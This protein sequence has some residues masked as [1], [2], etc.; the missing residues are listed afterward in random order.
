M[1][2]VVRNSWMA[3]EAYGSFNNQM[4]PYES[5]WEQKES[6]QTDTHTQPD[7]CIELRILSYPMRN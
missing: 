6:R 5:N 1:L 7:P 2:Q 4:E 3:V